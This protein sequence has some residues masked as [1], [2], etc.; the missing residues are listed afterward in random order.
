ATLVVHVWNDTIRATD[1]TPTIVE[2]TSVLAEAAAT[3][4][5]VQSAVAALA[6]KTDAN[7][8]ADVW[9]GIAEMRSAISAHM[10]NNTI[11]VTTDDDGATYLDNL[12]SADPGNPEGLFHAVSVIRAR[13][14]MHMA[15]EHGDFHLPSGPSADPH[16]DY[17]NV[18]VADAPSRGDR[19]SVIAAL[20]DVYRAY[21]AH[22]AEGS[23][24]HAASDTNNA[25]E[26]SLNP[27]LTV[28]H[29]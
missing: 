23:P 29:A 19:A 27:L 18:L 11:H 5:A 13:L 8:F 26:T 24:I 2:P 28:H 4:S 21:E 15:N 14:A 20:A 6:G 25:L 17:S 1:T 12:P 16:P 10:S 7:L 9:T 22:R 3:S